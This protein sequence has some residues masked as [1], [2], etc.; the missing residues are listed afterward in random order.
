MAEKKLFWL[1][2]T[3]DF[4]QNKLMKKLRYLPGG[5][6]YTL[7]YLKMLLY[8]LESNGIIQID[9]VEEKMEDEIA[10]C[11]DEKAEAIK[12]TLLFC[13]SNGLIV[14]LDNKDVQMNQIPLLTGSES[15]SAERKRRQRDREKN[16]EICDHVNDFPKEISS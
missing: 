5:A 1:K 11:I 9:G 16:K 8:S 6:D 13:I 12:M 10:L 14:V 3:T 4:F 2:L 7:V 15:A